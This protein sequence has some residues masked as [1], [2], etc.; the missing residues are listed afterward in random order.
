MDKE[1]IASDC[2]KKRI[3]ED[4]FNEDCVTVFLTDQEDNDD[5]DD[6]DEANDITTS[7]I[8]VSIACAAHCNNI[9]HYS[10]NVLQYILTSPGYD[11]LNQAMEFPAIKHLDSIINNCSENASSRMS[12]LYV[13]ES[14]FC[15]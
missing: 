7:S 4:E 1:K 10:C 11:K 9:Q 2:E 15:L 8:M 3:F 12:D 13:S 14:V 6:D 5:D